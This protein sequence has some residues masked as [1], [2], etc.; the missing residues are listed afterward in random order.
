MPAVVHSVQLKE[1]GQEMNWDRLIA[2]VAVLLDAGILWILVMEYNYDK[3]VYEKSSYKKR[4][5]KL[6]F[7]NL[8]VGEGK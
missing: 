4:T 7:E 6:A 2:V 3:I 5:H 8:T 1:G